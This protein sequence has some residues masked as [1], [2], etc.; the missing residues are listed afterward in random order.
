MNNTKTVQFKNPESVEQTCPEI[1]RGREVLYINGSQ[2]E[3]MGYT[4][5]D[6]IELTRIALTE[7]G[8]K[9]VEMPAKIGVHPI[10]DAFHHAMPAFVPAVRASGMKWVACFPGNHNYKLNQTS[11]LIILNDVQTGWPIAI[12]DG[13]WITEKRTAAVSALA[14][15][16][17]ASRDTSEIGIIGCGVQGQAHLMALAAVLRNL[18]KVKV[19]DIRPGAAKQMIDKFSNS[20]SFEIIEAS[21]VAA[22]V[23][24]SDVIVSA[25]AILK[26]AKPIVKD[27]WIKPGALLLPVDFDSVFEW[28]TMKRADKFLVDSLDEMNYLMSI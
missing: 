9:M 24:D 17:L 18:T 23:R 1:I 28:K 7:H 8:K 13:A 5:V 11:A 10:S 25:T 20:H 27:E 6:I 16:S 2:I 14:A 19:M 12:M 26:I 22:L 4:Y 15:E 3:N 21:S